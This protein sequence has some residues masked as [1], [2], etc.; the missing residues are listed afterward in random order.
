GSL[1]L[2]Y[3]ST[4]GTINA[5][6]VNYDSRMTHNYVAGMIGYASKLTIDHVLNE[7]DILGFSYKTTPTNTTY[8]GGIAGY[9]NLVS[10]NKIVNRGNITSH[11][12]YD[13]SLIY[14]GGIIGYQNDLEEDITY[15]Y[16][17]GDLEVGVYGGETVYVAGYGYITD[18]ESDIDITSIT[19]NGTLTF[20]SPGTLTTTEL[21]SVNVYAAGVLITNNTDGEIKGL[22]NLHSQSIDMSFIDKYAGNILAL[23]QSDLSIEQSYQSGDLSFYTSQ[24]LVNDYVYISANVY[25]KNLSLNHLRQEGDISF[26]MSNNSTTTLTSPFFYFYGLFEEASLGFDVTNGYQGGDISIE[27]STSNTISYDLYISGMGYENRNIEVFDT[28]EIDSQSIDIEEAVGSVDT[29]LNSGNIYITGNFNGH[30]KVAGILLYNQSILSNAINLGDIEIY[31]DVITANDQIEAGGIVYAMISEYAQIR[32]SANNGDIKVA[33]NSTLGYAHASGIAVRNDKNE[34]GTDISSGANHRFGK[35]M[36]SINY[37]DIYAYNGTSESSYTITNETRSKASGI[38]TLGILSVVNN[39]NYGNIFSRY[40]GAGIFGFVYYSKFDS[41]DTDEVYVS[42]LINYG[43]VRQITAY[44]STSHAFTYN[45]TTTPSTGLPYAFGAIVG[46]IHTGTSTW[47]FTGDVD[48]PI[49]S[50]YFGY[51]LNFDSKINMFSSAPPLSSNWSNALSGGLDDANTIIINMVQNMATTNPSDASV[52]PFTYFYAGSSWLGQYIGKVIDYYDV[53][54]A[55]TGMFYEYFPF[56]SPSAA[57]SGT[58]RYIDDYIEYVASSKVNDLIIDK[59]EAN[60]TYSYPGIYVLSSSSGINNGIFIPDNFVID[61]LNPYDLDSQEADTTWIGDTSQTDSVAYSLY[62]EMRQ[63]KVSFATTIYNLEIVQT[64]SNGNIINDGLTL[65]DPVIDEERKM[66]TYYLPSNAAVLGTQTASTL[67]VSK[68]VEV[69]DSYVDGARYVANTLTGDNVLDGY[70]WVGT[71]KKSGT[72]MVA[73]G[74]YATTGVYNLT[75]TDT[76]PY[77]TSSTSTVVYNLTSAADAVSATTTVFTYEPFVYTTFLWWKYWSAEGYRVTKTN[78]SAGYGAYSSHTE[79]SGGKSFT[80]YEYV[81]PYKSSLT[82]VYSA[83][84]SGVTVYPTSSVYFKANTEEDSYTI[85]DTASLDYQGTSYAPVISIPRSYGVYDSMYT[86]GGTYIDS[87]EDHY[88]AVRVYSQEYSTGDSSTY[89]DYDI[90]IIRTANE[91]IT[92]IDSL[93]LDGVSSLPGTF[94]VNSVTATTDLSYQTSGNNG[95]LSLTYETY[96]VSNLFKF[97]P[98]VEVFDNNTGVK[99]FTSLYKLTGGVV[100]TD[101]DFNNDTGSWGYGASTIV[102]EAE[103]DFPSG[104]YYIQLTLLSDETFK[105]YFSKEESGN[106]S[107]LNIT[108]QGET[109]ELDSNSYTSYIDYGIYYI[110]GQSETNVVDFT[111]LSTLNSVYYD[112]VDTNLPSYLEGMEISNF[113]EIF[114]ISYSVSIINGY[115]HQYAI[116]YHL[117]AEDGS[118]D[119]FTHYLLES[120]LDAAPSAIYKNGGTQDVSASTIIIGY[121]ESPTVRIEYGFDDVFFA[122]D[123]VLSVTSSFVPLIT[124]ETS[125]LD[126]DYFVQTINDIGY[127]VDLNQDISKGSYTYQLS[128]NQSVLVYGSTLTWQYTFNQVVLQKVENDNSHLDN[129]LFASES[130][131]DEVLDAFVT[132]IDI[133]EVTPTEYL[134]YFDETNPTTRIISVLPTTGIDYDQYA[135]YSSYWIIGQV[136]ETDLTA[137]QPTFYIPDGSNIYRVIDENNLDYSYQSTILAADFTDF[138]NGTTL[139]Y[140]H[141]RIYAEDYD[142]YP[143]HY[144][145]YYIAVQDS[146]NNIKFDISVENDTADLIEQVYVKVNVY[147]FASDYEG[148]LTYDDILI[149]MGLFSYYDSAS[150]TYDNNQFETSMYGFYVVLVELP[151]GYTFEL[152][153]DQSYIQGLIYLES[154]RIP[155]RYYVTVHIIEETPDTPDWGY[156][157]IFE[158]IPTAEP[159]DINATYT[160]GDRFIYNDITWIVIDSSYIYDQSNPPGTGAWQGLQDASGIYSSVSAYEIGD[161]VIYNGVYYEAIATNASYTNPVSGLGE[162]WNEISENWLYYNL[163]TTD[164]IVLYNGVYYISTASWNK[165]YQPDTTTWAWQVYN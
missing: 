47:A 65:T 68:Y 7:L 108:Y 152:E 91:D 130:V 110:N 145:D 139:N 14:M 114:Y 37:G 157:V 79:T 92:D 67:T 35:I 124:G 126:E 20:L 6:E 42:N 159:L 70:T 156:Q 38:L 120:P 128:Y 39:I 154:S 33:S 8:Y 163:Y 102:F 144:T 13:V 31:N 119:T 155:T 71:Y 141:Y 133:E 101:G 34:N 86:T 147:Q 22:F 32:D 137:Y 113:A 9:A 98:Y 127:E 58:D 69:G 142:D 104:D 109:I 12:T 116:V 158:Y 27:K 28:Y 100:V 162:A 74:P 135:S 161:I 48:Y 77:T 36:F 90:R 54:T 136:Q 131:F 44:N 103:D 125:T 151:E 93:T 2:S 138:G 83:S 88:G 105:V 99:V 160:S 80:V 122:T 106:A 118:T 123:Q 24:T 56:R 55:N 107:V 73:I 150:D 59:I 21:N 85:S 115:Q 19:N 17:N 1:D 140:V 4:T 60:T 72:S 26:Y 134:A 3:S 16:Q 63:I 143:T 121:Q 49:D 164:D 66:I 129:V 10:A 94:N 149:T 61:G 64:D 84:Q 89:Q 62:E 41:I 153:F 23:D 117:I 112:E 51:L 82:Y 132:I 75:T 146:T 53:S 15:I 87:V 45:M 52:E 5:I 97:L 18:Q 43:K 165:N 95:I 111:N 30:I 148:E 76:T 81:G 78:A 40:L 57:T 11:E 29:M 46:K 50:I 96:N 25:G